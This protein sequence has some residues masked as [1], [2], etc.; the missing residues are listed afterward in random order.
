MAFFEQGDNLSGERSRPLSSVTWS[1]HMLYMHV[2]C[3]CLF[4][5]DFWCMICLWLFNAC[6]AKCM[7]DAWNAGED[8]LLGCQSFFGLIECEQM[9]ANWLWVPMKIW[10]YDMPMDIGRLMNMKCQWKLI[11]G[12]QCEYRALVGCQWK[13]GLNDVKDNWAF[14][15]CQWIWALNGYWFECANKNWSSWNASGY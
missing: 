5:H 12:C 10:L 7:I 8:G 2:S 3:I 15:R 4:M 14:S 9:N 13:L 6:Y 11:F 1:L